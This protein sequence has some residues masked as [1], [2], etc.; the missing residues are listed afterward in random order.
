MLVSLDPPSMLEVLFL[1][2]IATFMQTFDYRASVL[3]NVHWNIKN[4]L[5]SVILDDS[6]L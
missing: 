6:K 2:E 3:I 1:L 5:Y 4:I